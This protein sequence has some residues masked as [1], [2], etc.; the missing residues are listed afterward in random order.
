MLPD[1][2]V[3]IRVRQPQL[4]NR[5]AALGGHVVL[6]LHVVILGFLAAVNALP[7]ATG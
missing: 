1:I 5:D 4:S 3:D 2:P 7:A 6:A